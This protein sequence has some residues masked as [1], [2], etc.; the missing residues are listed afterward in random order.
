MIL[1]YLFAKNGKLNYYYKEN[2]EDTEYTL[3]QYDVKFYVCDTLKT[4]ALRNKIETTIEDKSSFA[5]GN[6]VCNIYAYK[7]G[8][9]E[10]LDAPVLELASNSYDKYSI[11][12]TNGNNKTVTF[13][14][15]DLD[16]TLTIEKDTSQTF[17]IEWGGDT[18]TSHTVTGYFS[19]QNCKDSE[20]ASLSVTRPTKTKLSAPDIQVHTNT[21]YL[22]G[23]RY[24]NQNSISVT[25][26]I[27]GTAYSIGGSEYKDIEQK[28]STIG[29]DT[30]TA[31]AYCTASGYSD[32][33]ITTETYT[34][35]ALIQ[36]EA[37]TLGS[38]S[39]S[40][41]YVLI[42]VTNPN[43]VECEVYDNGVKMGTVSANSSMTYTIYF[44]S[45]TYN[46]SVL[47]SADTTQ[48]K[49]SSA[50]TKTYYRPSLPE[51]TYGPSIS[52]STNT[53]SSVTFNVSNKNSYSVTFSTNGLT[54]GANST[55]QVSHTWGSSE[56]TYTLRGYFYKSGY[57]DST[58]GSAS[59]TKPTTTQ[60]TAPSLS[61]TTKT[62]LGTIRYVL[63]IKN[64]NSVACTYTLTGDSQESGTVS[65]N[66]S[67]TVY[68]DYGSS[69]TV[70]CYLLA[71]G[72]AQSKETSLTFG[73]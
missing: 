35:P 47:L 51:I 33:D 28:W 36:L 15:Q 65:A 67:A 43:S 7:N 4:I 56:S 25:M 44:T 19:A 60:L 42:K 18:V 27:N 10:T 17:E 58:Y 40:Y 12:V 55:A 72:Y 39:S 21:N 31:S 71:S 45:S 26:Y 41:E 23:L 52:I 14:S 20:Y 16:G 5:W 64:Y 24:Y 32:S 11:K 8:T 63:T 73:G 49:E 34:R 38:V 2:Q 6:A 53:S 70:G 29:A 1:N 50:T 3:T 69:Y 48:Y 37:P 66:G 57:E 68:F 13:N 30:F 9:K 59:A 54:I 22:L 61:Y 46:A 62:V